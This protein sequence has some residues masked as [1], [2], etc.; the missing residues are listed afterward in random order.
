MVNFCKVIFIV[1]FSLASSKLNAQINLNTPN[2]ESVLYLGDHKKQALVVGL[3]GSEGGNSWASDYWKNTR[4]QFL[5]QGYAFLALGY[6][7]ANNTPEILDRISIDAVY[8]AIKTAAA[9]KQVEQKHIAVVGGS[10]GADLALLLAAYYDD[11][12]CV[13]SIVGSHTVFPGHTDHFT[14]SC[15]S[16]NDAELPF[17][18]V[19]DACI[20]FLMEGDLRGTF[21]A[22]LQDTVASEKSSYSNRKNQWANFIFYQLIKMRY[23]LPHQWLIIWLSD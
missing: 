11:I 14:T 10:R 22:M 17:V 6:F 20:P 2:V 4:D 18:P 12:D 21:E 16:Y 23:V 19:N 5:E 9:H 13:V 15:W 1:L 7:G 8:T 3:G